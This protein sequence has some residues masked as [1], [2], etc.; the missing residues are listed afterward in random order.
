MHTRDWEL[1]STTARLV[2]TDDGAAAPAAALVDEP[3]G[4]GG[5][6][7][8]P[9]RPHLGADAAR[10]RDHPALA[11]AG[12]APR[13]RARRRRAD[14]R[15]RRP[16]RSVAPWSPSATT[17][18][19]TRCPRRPARCGSS[20]CPGWRGVELVRRRADPPSRGPARPRGDREG[21]GRGPR[22]PAGGREARHRGPAGARRRPR[23]RRARARGR[24]AGA[25]AGPARRSR[26][27][28]HAGRRCRRGDAPAP[29]VAP[30]PT[31]PGTTSSTRPPGAPVVRRGAP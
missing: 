13:R 23:D 9:L 19:C 5:R 1:W 12:H 27:A 22:R 20:T 25:G 11:D 17:A 28:G 14:R 15:R 2:V 31:A 29:S 21:T 18:T 6:R 8:Q 7:L 30:G 26:P 4:R 16:H 24:V 10:P 3:A